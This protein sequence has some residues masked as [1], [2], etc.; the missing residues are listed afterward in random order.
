M[1]GSLPA[2]HGAQYLVKQDDVQ[3]LGRYVSWTLS[4]AS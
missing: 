3:R 4:I 1:A 2:M